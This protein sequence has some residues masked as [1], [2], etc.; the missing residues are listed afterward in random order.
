MATVE[1]AD[2]PHLCALGAVAAAFGQLELDLFWNLGRKAGI[3][4]EKVS[5]L[6]AGESFH[7]MLGKLRALVA[8][9]EADTPHAGRFD[10]WARKMSEAADRRNQML[11]SA[12]LDLRYVSP[13]TLAKK[14]PSGA[15][16]L[17]RLKPGRKKPYENAA[18]PGHPVKLTDL[19]ALSDRL[20]ELSEELS[21]LRAA[22]VF[23][24]RSSTGPEL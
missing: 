6:L 9:E 20:R 14:W 4:P 24:S 8:Y 1:S 19:T 22:G 7:S 15:P 18:V 21:E 17:L 3:P 10:T 2:E 12:W 13:E 16:D 11:H 5:I 23:E